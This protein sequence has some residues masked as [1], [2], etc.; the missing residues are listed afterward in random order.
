MNIFDVHEQIINDYSSY[1]ES[2]VNIKN[3]F[4]RKKVENEISSGKLW[5]K[6]LLKSGQATLFEAP[7]LFN[8][9]SLIGFESKVTIQKKD[10]ASFK[11]HISKNAVKGKFTGE[12]KQITPS[13][14]LAENMFGRKVGH[15]FLFG[16]LEYKILELE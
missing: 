7:N 3:D 12:Y 14:S 4:I 13:S 15:S 1:I 11:Y 6:G 16:G 10:G 8:Q 5:P 9:D 2:F